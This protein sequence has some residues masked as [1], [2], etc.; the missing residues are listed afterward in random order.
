MAPPKYEINR[1]SAD[2][3]SY[4][5][6]I[7]GVT[8][9]STVEQSRKTL[10]SLLKLEREATPIDY[11]A[12]PFSF[13]DDTAALNA[14]IEEVEDILNDFDGEEI[15]TRK[16]MFSKIA[17]L[18]GRINKCNASTAAEKATRSGIMV[19]ILNLKSDLEHKIKLYERTVQNH[20]LGVPD[21]SLANVNLLAGSSTSSSSDEENEL[22]ISANSASKPRIKMV[23]IS[24]WNLKFTGERDGLS[25]SA[26]LERVEEMKVARGACDR[27]LFNSAIDLFSGKA[28]IW[29]RAMRKSAHDW[30][31]L[32]TLLREEFQPHDYNDKLFLEIKNRTQGPSESIGMYVAI[33]NGL[34]SRLTIDVSQGTKIKILLNNILPFY[35]TQLALSKIET[36]DELLKYGRMLEARKSSAESYCPP[37]SRKS[38]KMLEPDLA[39]V[40][41]SSSNDGSLID[42][43]AI[44][45]QTPVQIKCFNCNKIGHVAR[46][47]DQPFRLRCYKCQKPNYT[48]RTCPDCSSS[49]S[50]NGFLRR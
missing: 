11:P 21:L 26:F 24:Q 30:S 12:Y 46:Y 1:L 23:P 43:N 35:Q 39:Y 3:L 48:V 16:K 36:I 7:R 44:S 47:C 29:Y 4:E 42:L 28:L 15:S 32:V 41:A 19:K 34:F 20:T 38:N 14:K 40:E 31:S 18:L 13:A 45:S 22:N 9:V 6:A 50:G 17:Y 25:L 37:P 5:L 2:E 8:N 49:S 27:D 10:R 33:M